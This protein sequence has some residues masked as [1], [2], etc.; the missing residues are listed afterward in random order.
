MWRAAKVASGANE[1]KPL[2]IVVLFGDIK[3]VS[4]LLEKYGKI[5]KRKKI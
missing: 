4:P 5:Q 1:V 2:S 3:V